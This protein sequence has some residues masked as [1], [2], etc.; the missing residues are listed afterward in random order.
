MSVS[1]KLILRTSKILS[2]GEHP[3][4]LRITINR[5]SQFVT[6]KKTSSVDHWDEQGQSVRK[7]HPDNKTINPLLKNINSKTDLYLLNAGEEESVVNFDDIK[8]I[9]LKLT[10]TDR[11]IKTKSLF[12]FF[13]EEIKRLKSQDRL[14][15]AETYQSTLNCI[16]RFTNEKD[17]AFIN[18]QLDFL[19]KFEVHLIE[20]NC[21]ITTRSVY[22]RTFRTLW[23]TAIKDKLCPEKHYPFKDFAF[24][25]YNA[26]RTKKRAISKAQIDK[27]LE[28]KIDPKNDAIL[29]SRNYFMFS[30]Y[31][32][33]LNFTD[34]ASLKWENIVDGEL[35]YTRAKTGEEFRFK[36]HGLALDIIAHYEN[37]D[38]NSDAGYIFPILYKRHATSASIRDRKKKILKR[39]NGDIKELAKSVGIEKTVTTYV[40]RH[41]YATI[42]RTNG[43]SKEVISQSLG[44]DSLKTTDIYL[45]DI[46]DPVLDALIN[47]A[48]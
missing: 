12:S 34:L 32:R 15:Y 35:N 48:L 13:E 8:Q 4:M 29:N 46:G 24:S 19:R 23:K 47:A 42:L 9:V 22:F 11:E 41:S 1:T 45:D 27:I 21:A 7:T 43:I 38:G 31:C 10:S 16:K 20:R 6:T 30:F 25:K 5:Q 2:N 28:I 3:I 18:I 36:L 40:A 39:V 26:P 44:H 14:G 37:M 17:Y 33:G